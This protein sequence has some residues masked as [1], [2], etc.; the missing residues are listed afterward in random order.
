MTTEYEKLGAF[1]LGRQYDLGAQQR[2][3]DLVLYDSKDLTTH[4][5]IIGMTGSG[6]T[7]L[8]IGLLE[9]ALIDQVPVIA[10]DPK[11][12][13]SNLKLT[14]PDLSAK[15]VA[16]W[17]DPQ[18][19]AK[20]GQSVA[21]FAAGQA[22]LWRSGLKKW[23]QFPERIQRL[24]DAAP[25][26]IYTPGSSA[27]QPVSVLK[28]F[29]P[30]PKEIVDDTDLFNE[31]IQTTT[32]GLLT[33]LGKTV[34]PI[35]SREHILIANI[36]EHYWRKGQGLDLSALIQAIQSP[37]FKRIGVME[38]DLIFPAGERFDLAMQLN[39]LLAAP[40]FD[41][42]LK[43][44]PLD[45]GRFLYTAE[46]KPKASIFSIS[47]LF[48][49]ERMFFVSMLLNEILGWM[50]AQPGTP[51]L[52]AI[53]YMDEV[54]GYL[55]PI[56]NPPSKKP[57][58]T[59][60][61]Q[62]RA[63]GLGVVLATQNPVD[64]DY[65]GLSNTGTW[66]IG[67]LQTE[68]D[69]ER[70]L[71]GLEG[72][73]ADAGFDRKMMD[74]TL[75]ALAKRTFWLHNVH[76]NEPV[77]FQTRWV[78]SY[79]RGPLTRDQ[80]K[81]LSAVSPASPA[82]RITG[83]D[84][85]ALASDESSTATSNVVNVAPAP[86]ENVC[87]YYLAASGT[88]K[89]LVYKPALAARLDVHYGNVRYKVDTTETVAMICEM[90][91]STIALDWDR[92]R[93][94]LTDSFRKDG[95]AD[96]RYQPLPSAAKKKSA[97][98]KW[99]KDLLRWVRQNRPLSLL[100]SPAHKMVSEVGESQGAFRARLNQLA[101]E[102][103]DL[104][105][106]KLKLKYEKRFGFLKDRL[107]RAELAIAREAEQAR[108]KKMQTAVSF[109]TAILGAV[110]GRKVLSSTSATKF[111]SAM[112]SA[113]SMQK[114]KMDVARAQEKA[115]AIRQQMLDLEAKFQDELSDM[116]FRFDAEMEELTSIS[117]KPKSSD[118]TL[119]LFGLIWVPYRV[120]ADSTLTPDWVLEV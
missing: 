98:T 76:E 108:S 89:Q 51:S 119:E 26:T 70:V 24:K 105:G 21:Q 93:E 61:K 44:E 13:L 77:I 17:V 5:V 117:V 84:H 79:L 31:R 109:G 99:Q 113:S 107:M 73:A 22:E 120:E 59:L 62:A 45:V 115:D 18:A 8:G 71:S 64:L 85:G 68:Q 106:E 60:L 87:T 4:A 54:F 66:F 47:H 29:S 30:P 40:G 116:E 97:Y 9:E 57:M 34:N 16:P 7:G 96:V 3:D 42:W 33:L 43:G 101:R 39:N 35:T 49:T 88:A 92:S 67:R 6:K 90:S 83:S 78:L 15:S 91:D 110:L 48:D 27:G 86:P 111:G 55:P 1:Y 50:R 58:L 53:L 25:V 23:G 37:P 75:S 41:A 32:T 12:D 74:Q 69:K 95:F 100:Q 2:Q 102:K 28:N 94:V 11:G 112:R 56:G 65:K 103:R 36:F 118:I 20:K 63:F 81:T 52:R 19:A 38:L 14:F 72:V 80:M 82:A 104:A 46:G 114:E 10:I